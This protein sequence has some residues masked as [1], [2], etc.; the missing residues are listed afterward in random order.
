MCCLNFLKVSRSIALQIV[1][2]GLV[3]LNLQAERLKK[4]NVLE[5][6]V[7]MNLEDT[8]L[9]TVLQEI[10]RQT[11]IHFTY[12][13][14]KLA[15]DT[16]VSVQVK[17]E[18]LKSVLKDLSQSLDLD[19]E[20]FN[21]NTIV[22]KDR[23]SKPF[24]LNAKTVTGTVTASSGETLIGATVV[25][26]GTNKGTITGVNGEYSIEAEEGEVLVFS[27]I[28]YEKKEVTV[29][30]QS[31][32]DVVLSTAELEGVTVIG[33]RGKPRTNID[34]PV[35]IDV[36]STADLQATNQVDIGQALHYTVPSFSA[37]KFGINDLAPLI[38]PAQLRGLGSDQT[39]LLVNGKRRHKV[40]FFSNN[41][42]VGKG[43][44][45][46]D[47]NAIPSAAVRQTEVLRDGAAAQ[48]GSDA[49]AGVVNLQLKDAREGGSLRTYTGVAFTSPKYDDLTTAKVYKGTSLAASESEA[50]KSGDK[51]Y[52][53]DPVTDGATFTTEL[54]FGLPWG[55]QGFINV[56]GWYSHAEPTDRS[57]TY[58]HSAGWYTNNAV[59]ENTRLKNAGI[60]SLDRAVLGT[61]ENTNGGIFINSGR[62]L[63]EDWDFYA[64]G[65]VSMK[66]IIGGVF[67][68][69]PTR[70]GRRVL[71]IFPDGYNPEV[72]SVLTDWQ[73]LSGAKGTVG[74]DWNMDFSMGYS[75]NNLDLYARNTVNPSLGVASPTRFYTGS[76]N[77]TQTVFN[78]DISKV[79]GRTSVA[80]GSEVRFESYQQSQGDI[81]SYRADTAVKNKDIGSSGREG[82]SAQ[83][84]GE[85]YRNNVGIY[86]EV[87][88]E[89]TDD[90][91]VSAAGR[92]E[93]Y[94]DF[95]ADFSYKVAARYKIIDDIL[96]FRASLN[97][98]FRAPALGQVNYSNFSQISFDGDGNSVVSPFLPIR[99]SRVGSSLGVTELKPET[100]FDIAAGITSKPLDG[101]SLTVDFYQIKIENRIMVAGVG[102][103][104]FSAFSGA[105][106]DDINIF[107]NA[108][109][110]T[111]TG[112]DVV[113]DY[114]RFISEKS[115][116]GI[117]LAYNN[118]RTSVDGFNLP[119]PL[120]DRI[121]KTSDDVVYL[122]E[123]TPTN[124]LI[125]S[126]FFQ[127]GAFTFLVRA[128]RFGEV[129]EARIQKYTQAQADAGDI[130]QDK[131]GVFDNSGKG[132]PQIMAAKIIT[133]FSIS[134]KLAENFSITAGVNNLFDV[135]P[136]ML[137]EAQV[138]N[139]V[140]YSRRVNQFGTVGRFINI[141]L[142]YSW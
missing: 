136:D 32:I 83:T 18:S 61:A 30:T 52:G 58:L 138:R 15:A 44:L 11:K 49:I 40:A 39:L 17:D 90:L 23:F 120:K 38:D 10:E 25:I 3:V 62:P 121:T 7:S 13:V 104:G 94:S 129:T 101:L 125:I 82:F 108:L 60:T 126:P 98:S 24:D 89:I 29:G 5:T 97:R 34:R 59:D 37:Q 79:L 64:F 119:T 130:A 21:G 116:A 107:T 50:A 12:S 67:S 31:V 72:P 20:V 139:E 91:L 26:K 92:F 73:I 35:P 131:V 86:A 114:K 1:L 56:T 69:S 128:S 81:E 63:N 137:G 124:K 6:Q 140:I 105:G 112:F 71:E 133:D 118:N 127:A 76:L 106:Y 22:L 55:E 28:G 95:G 70:T 2:A 100:S 65:G 109:N 123:G 87:E 53:D 135:Y 96:S 84:D 36:V 122:I 113:V 54:N 51:I 111:T 27:Y 43:Q 14:Q 134:A 66:E 9:K 19:Y 99:D 33:S 46:N 141:S 142:N 115:S 77:V 4:L 68:R 78:A 102:A 57:G 132:D 48:Y 41:A 75:G 42:G 47:I 88:S 93:N 80:V 8:P 103:S 74:D 110:T 16:K 117:T 85:W 45:G